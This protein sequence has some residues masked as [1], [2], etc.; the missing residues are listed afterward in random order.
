MYNLRDGWPGGIIEIKI[1]LEVIGQL[2][3]AEG[4]QSGS[5]ETMMRSNGG[6]GVVD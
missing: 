1:G 3:G 2:N 5:L 4:M 6:M